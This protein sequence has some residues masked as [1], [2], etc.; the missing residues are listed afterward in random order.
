MT[1]KS[2]QPG[3]T[4]TP[5]QMRYA[6]ILEPGMIIGLLS[7]L[8]TFCIYSFGILDPY[9][10]LEKI[11][12]YWS[13]NV[14]DYL[15]NA[16]ISNGWAWLGM[17]GYGDFINFI[18]IAILGGVTIL[19]YLAIIPVLLKNRDRIYALLALLEVIIL[20]LAASG[21]ITVGH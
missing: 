9:V 17:I 21:M 4:A 14:D 8:V 18:G 16:G 5:E 20:S 19:C 12:R 1:E 3:L 7:L 11:S 10:P 6:R 15:R 13:M 2:Q